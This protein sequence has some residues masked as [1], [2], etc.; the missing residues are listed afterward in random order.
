MFSF[1][2]AGISCFFG[3][4]TAPVFFA[5]TGLLALWLGPC[6]LALCRRVLEGVFGGPRLCRFRKRG[7]VVL[8]AVFELDRVSRRGSHC[9]T[10]KKMT[11]ILEFPT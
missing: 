6:G 8:R 5:M 1:G 7:G 11:K 10:C 2:G 9:V 4:A 3:A